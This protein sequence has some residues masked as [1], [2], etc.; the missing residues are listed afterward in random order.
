MAALKRLDGDVETAM[1]AMHR[2]LHTPHNARAFVT[3]KPGSRVA[4]KNCRFLER[5]VLQV[6]NFC[7]LDSVT[8]KSAS[9]PFAG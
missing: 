5:G 1:A 4:V 2:S 6:G 8:Y 9:T 7:R 3:A